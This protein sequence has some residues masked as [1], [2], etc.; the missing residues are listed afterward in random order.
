[1]GGDEVAQ[2]Q[3]V[4]LPSPMD[5]P[6]ASSKFPDRGTCVI[7]LVKPSVDAAWVR[8]ARANRILETS[9]RFK[10]KLGDR[11]VFYGGEDNGAEQWNMG[12]G[13]DAREGLSSCKVLSNTGVR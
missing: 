3:Q 10:K 6:R 11:F 2:H 4:A 8:T 9:D 1:M 12:S 5:Q 7:C 13:C